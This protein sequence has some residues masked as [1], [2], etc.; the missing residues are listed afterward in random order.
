VGQVIFGNT[1]GNSGTSNSFLNAPWGIKI[2][3]DNSILITDASNK[4]ILFVH[5]NS[6]T[7]AIVAGTGGDLNFP[8]KA[9]FDVAI[10]P[11][12]YVLDQVG[13]RMMLWS[14]NSSINGTHLFGSFGSSLSQLNYPKSFY[15]SSNKSF[16]IVDSSNHRIL[17]WLYNAS[18]GS[19]IAGITGVPGNDTFHL[20]NPA[21]IFV[22]E[23]LGQMY[24]ADFN[25]HRIV[26]Y[27]IGSLNGTVVAGGNGPGAQRK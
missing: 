5:A 20:N 11:N 6:S 13:N 21:D 16:Y 17:L 19:V 12:L 10:P 9:M 24:V 18:N 7:G 3:A 15:L 14:N 23:Q 26:K 27:T 22:D 4:R 8:S 25:N 1:N 2:N